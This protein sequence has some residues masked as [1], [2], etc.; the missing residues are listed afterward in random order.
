MGS[1][2][3][4]TSLRMNA[5]RWGDIRERYNWKEIQSYYDSGFNINQINKKYNIPKTALNKAI[6]EGLSKRVSI[7]ATGA[8]IRYLLG[9][10]TVAALGTSHIIRDCERL[11]IKVNSG[12][13]IAVI[14]NA[15]TNGTLEITELT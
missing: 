4:E 1:I 5:S 3:K 11:D 7:S 15:A 13:Y 2:N 9:G 10:A 14:R 12:E 6:K 8:D